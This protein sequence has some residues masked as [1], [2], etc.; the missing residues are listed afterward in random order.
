MLPAI[1]MPTLVIQRL[2]DL[3]TPACHGRYLAEHIPNARYFEQPGCHL[4]WLDDSEAML[5]EIE[6][7]LSGLAGREPEPDRVLVTI[8]YALTDD[9]LAVA[10]RQVK[11]H[12]GRLIRSTSEYTMAT[13]DSPVRAIRCAAALRDDA[14]A[15]GIA[16]RA[17]VHAGE[18]EFTG[19]DIGGVSG[20]VAAA[21]AGAARPGEIL[22]SRIV[23]DLVVGSGIAFADGGAQ[24]PPANG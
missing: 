7:F 17:G 15:S 24:R 3:I 8:L 18:V 12:R 5:A 13:F 11:A 23:K 9:Q 1:H 19:E 2:D 20:Q 14:S 21:V 22:T 10:G 16:L 6:D 4:P